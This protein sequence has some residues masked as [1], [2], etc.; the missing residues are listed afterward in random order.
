MLNLLLLVGFSI[1]VTEQVDEDYY[2]GHEEVSE[3]LWHF[4]VHSEDR[5]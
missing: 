2:V 5:H 4:A 1:E 3:S